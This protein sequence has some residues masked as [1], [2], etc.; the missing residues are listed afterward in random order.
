MIQN[1]PN[2]QKVTAAGICFW[3]GASFHLNLFYLPDFGPV[4]DTL[5][6]SAITTGGLAAVLMIL[7]LEFTSGG[8]EANLED[9]LR[10]LQQHDTQE[11]LE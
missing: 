7:Y 5:F 9:R 4:W 10:Q 8:N 2:R 11:P 1:E 3:I 6:K